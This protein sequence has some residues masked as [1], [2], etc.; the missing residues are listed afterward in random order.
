MSD[1]RVCLASWGVTVPGFRS[2]LCHRWLGHGS[3]GKEFVSVRVRGIICLSHI[4]DAQ[5][6]GYVASLRD[7]SETKM[8]IL[9]AVYG[10]LLKTKLNTQNSR[11]TTGAGA[12]TSP[13]VATQFAQLHRWS[14][15]YLTSLFLATTNLVLLILVFRFKTQDGMFDLVD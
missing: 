7:G 13:L 5:A 14:F 12:L 3:P 8:G 15:H 10:E 2:C 1:A 9:H 11:S 6:N 4:K